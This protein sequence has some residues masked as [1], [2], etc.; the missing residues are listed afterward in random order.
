MIDEIKYKNVMTID[1]KSK[2]AMID[3]LFK[4]VENN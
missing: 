2:T 4:V 1:N 3:L